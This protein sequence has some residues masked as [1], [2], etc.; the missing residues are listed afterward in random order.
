MPR[1]SIPTGAIKTAVAPELFPCRRISIPTGA[2]KRQ[3]NPVNTEYIIKIS[4]PSGAI[5][6]Q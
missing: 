2:I 4:I 3:Q 1:I 5:K 6:R